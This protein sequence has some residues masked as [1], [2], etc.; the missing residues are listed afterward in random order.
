MSKKKPVY[1]SIPVGYVC[2]KLDDLLH[3]Q[4]VLDARDHEITYIRHELY[5]AQDQVEDLK[6]QLSDANEKVASLEEELNKQQDSI[7]YWFNKY[8]SLCNE[9]EKVKSN[10]KAK[11]T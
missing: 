7:M 5:K 2:V 3:N 11:T 1:V 8:Q 10:A 4:C 6:K 9:L